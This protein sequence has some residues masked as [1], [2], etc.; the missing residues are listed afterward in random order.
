[1]SAA[2]YP[3]RKLRMLRALT[4]YADTYSMVAMANVALANLRAGEEFE[5]PGHG[6]FRALNVGE[7]S[8]RLCTPKGVRQLKVDSPRFE[9]FVRDIQG[10]LLLQMWAGSGVLLDVLK[11]DPATVRFKEGLYGLQDR[12]VGGQTL[13][14]GQ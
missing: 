7:S 3:N 6:L 11:R 2:P 13:G 8:L 9:A 1:V 14:S 4:S 12:V 10:P 5:V